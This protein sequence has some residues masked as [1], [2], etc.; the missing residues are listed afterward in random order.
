MSLH[1]FGPTV[2]SFS[3]DRP[4]YPQMLDY[5]NT[6]FDVFTDHEEAIDCFFGD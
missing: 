4:S 1:L 5:S 6:Q 2:V 3:G